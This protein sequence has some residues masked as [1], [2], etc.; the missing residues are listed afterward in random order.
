LVLGLLL[1]LVVSI[2]ELGAHIQSESELVIGIL[3][4]I[5]LDESKD[6]W[7]IDG[8]TASVDDGVAD[9]SDQNNKSSWCVVMLRVGPDEQD[10]M[11]DW[12]EKVNH[13]V[14]L[15]GRVGKL[16]EQVKEGLQIKEVLSGL[17]SGDLNLFL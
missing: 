5:S 4:L 2:L 16:I 10:S 13:L 6:G 8:S 3:D 1:V 11:H 7:A 15:L 12:N 17:R 14:Q 9:L